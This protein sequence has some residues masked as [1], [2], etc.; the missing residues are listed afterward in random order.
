MGPPTELILALKHE[1]SI[2]DF[3]E[4]GT[5][6]GGTSTWAAYH[7]DRV[8]TI[9]NSRVIYEQTVAKH[10]HIANIEFLFGNSRDV[11]K[12][13]VPVLQ[14]P[15][16]FWLDGHWCGG[17][18]FG[19]QDECCLPRLRRCPI[20]LTPGRPLQRLSTGFR[21]DLPVSIWSF[22]M[23]SSLL[24]LNMRRTLWQIGANRLPRQLRI[25]MGNRMACS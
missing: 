21:Q 3:V 12:S 7:F 23:M 18:S 22:W 25:R 1:F 16:L 13:V 4:T 20:E 19:E 10:G 6:Q 15:S 5:F 24:F 8:T 9:E 11:L 2:T 14:S 17:D